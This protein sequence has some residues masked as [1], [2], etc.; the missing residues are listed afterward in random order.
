MTSEASKPSTMVE[1]FSYS[2]EY[3]SQQGKNNAKAK[4]MEMRFPLHT[5]ISTI[6]PTCSGKSF[7]CQHTLVPK[8]R[9]ELIAQGV[10]EPKIHYLSSD[11]FRRLLLDTR[12]TDEEHQRHDKYDQRML[13]VSNAAFDLLRYTLRQLLAFPV[14]S[15]FV[16]VDTT[17]LSL[18]YHEEMNKLV[19]EYNYSTA[20]LVWDFRS[21]KDFFHWT[22]DQ[23]QSAAAAD[24]PGASASAAKS[25]TGTGAGDTDRPKMR[26]HKQR[27]IIGDQVRGNTR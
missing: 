24:E 20:C 13:E 2:F 18:Q 10:P 3:G 25:A 8:L 4:P 14:Q 12:G 19:K 7:Y 23:A 21:S 22:H 16:I 5:V 9:E 17:G 26:A 11:D 15:H 6:G 1:E 27:K